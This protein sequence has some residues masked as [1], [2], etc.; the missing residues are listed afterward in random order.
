MNGGPP[1]R[2]LSNADYQLIKNGTLIT[3]GDYAGCVRTG[4]RPNLTFYSLEPDDS[5]W[6]LATGIPGESQCPITAGIWA[7]IQ[8]GGTY[9]WN[10]KDEVWTDS[11]NNYR[12]AGDAGDDV[13]LQQV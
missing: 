12:L 9:L 4:S 10:A 5:N 7:K 13:E 3:S 8:A 6:G 11:G 1:D 2:R